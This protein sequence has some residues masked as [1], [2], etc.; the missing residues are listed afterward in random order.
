MNPFVLATGCFVIGA[1]L[2]MVLYR[3]DYCMV[4]MLRDF[5]LI[6][7]RTLLRS[8]LIYLLT[9]VVLV[10]IGR[11]TGF[12]AV[13]P[14]YT[15]AAASMMTVAGGFLFGIGMVL[16]GGCVISTLYRMAAGHTGNW[17][18]FSGILLGSMLYAEIHEQVTQLAAATRLT[19]VRVVAEISP[20]LEVLLVVSFVVL[21]LLMII[22][23]LRQ[24]KLTVVCHARGYIE[25]WRVALF[26]GCLNFLFYALS[27]APMGVTTGYAKMAAFLESLVIPAHVRTLRF[28]QEDTVSLHYGKSMLAGGAAPVMDLIGYT[29]L[30]LIGGIF[31]GSLCSALIC[32]EFRVYGLPPRRQIV[33]SFIG[34]LLLALG[35]RFA[36]GCNVKFF[37][38]GLPLLALQSFFFILAVLPGVRIGIW[39]LTRLVI[40]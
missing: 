10:S 32:R 35:A 16:A 22:R 6:G 7:D 38:G 4:A 17:I 20:K 24:G 37:L 28:F 33:S 21:A 40:R 8:F 12:I 29:E 27:G 25:P 30:P 14:P 13:F 39:L 5:F 23:W 11:I 15:F 26:I 31:I 36:S 18:A 2:G 3:G 9:F 1:L 19:S 34:G